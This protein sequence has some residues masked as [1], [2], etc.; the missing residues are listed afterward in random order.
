[1]SATYNNVVPL[2]AVLDKEELHIG[3]KDVAC[4]QHTTN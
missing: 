1:M 3:S 4:L 2:Q